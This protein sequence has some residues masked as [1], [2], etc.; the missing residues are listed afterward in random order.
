M[1]DEQAGPT[2]FDRYTGILAHE[3]RTPM[4]VISGYLQLLEDNQVLND[5]AMLR[6][7]LAV[8]QV[9]ARDMAR[10]VSELTTFDDLRR[11]EPLAT[12]AGNNRAVSAIV[13]ELAGHHAVL[14]DVESA[15]DTA[16]VD[17][18]RLRLG[19]QVLLENAVTHGAAPA[20]VAVRATL[21]AVP[22]CLV[23]RVSNQG[24]AIPQA[25]REA[26][27]QPFRQ[28]ED[29][30]SRRKGGLGLGLAIARRA[31]EGTGGSLVLE[32]GDP[33][34]FRLELPLRQDPLAVRAV[35]LEQ[36]TE[37]ADA[38]ALR[39]VQDLRLLHDELRK[40]RQARQL[41]E[42]QQLRAVQDFR[43]RHDTANALEAR[44]ATLSF[45]TVTALAR[46][47]EARDGHTGEHVERVRAGSVRLGQA[48]GLSGEP[49]RALEFGAILHDAG[50][51]AL[52]DAVLRK[53]GPLDAAE[54]EEMHRHPELGRRLLEGIGFL[55]PALDAVGCHHERW[56]GTGYPEGLTAEAIPLA[57]RIVAVVDAY[58]AMVSD[59]SYRQK[60]P[61]EAA[62]AEIAAGSGTQ[63]DPQVAAAFLRSDTE[64]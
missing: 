38:Q 64:T 63:F 40:E 1:S 25:L 41:A 13:R 29:Y 23:V 50:K 46:A 15:A 20:E 44:L 10:L 36:R 55:E 3:L 11:G 62:R 52:P 31:I 49:L 9:R 14:V 58:D 57:G 54:W 27:F 30:V 4:T 45:V 53:P 22:P 2:P 32:P 48:L 35:E 28:A 24:P 5:P 59:R 56:D 6:E 61:P 7:F 60:M 34:T 21:E 8:V 17:R 18:E 33:T 26:I 42:Q 43:T 47:I 19:L 37:Q 51:I 12:N 16:P 39:T